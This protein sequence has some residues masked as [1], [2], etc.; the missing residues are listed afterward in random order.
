[1]L[2]AARAVQDAETLR[3][4]AELGYLSAHD[5]ILAKNKEEL[6]KKNLAFQKYQ[7]DQGGRNTLTF[8]ANQLR[9]LDKQQTVAGKQQQ[10]FYHYSLQHAAG[11]NET[12]RYIKKLQADVETNRIF[13]T[14]NVAKYST[15]STTLLKNRELDMKA[16]T[17]KWL[18][19]GKYAGDAAFRPEITRK[20]Q[21]DVTM[22]AK[23]GG[24]PFTEG[25]ENKI[26]QIMDKA[27]RTSS[28]VDIASHHV[29]KDDDTSSGSN[30]HAKNP[31][32][33]I[34]QKHGDTASGGPDST[35][36]PQHQMDQE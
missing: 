2:L 4:K 12:Q 36:T 24:Q 8:Q 14:G 9:H 23:R 26:H 28:V 5:V 17:L 29:V 22:L 25:T 35:H 20:L 30:V 1:M 6:L 13:E 11:Q 16:A 27:Q 32:P 15:A 18:Q 21:E 7:L 19:T 3:K 33:N 34:N 10:Q 31:H